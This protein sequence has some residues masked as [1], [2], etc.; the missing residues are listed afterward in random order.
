MD[1]RI[2]PGVAGTGGEC[3]REKQTHNSDGLMKLFVDK[4]NCVDG[5]VGSVDSKIDIGE[6]R[7]F[8]IEQGEY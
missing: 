6:H 4:I 7:Y 3:I 8:E 2:L 1:G 5:I